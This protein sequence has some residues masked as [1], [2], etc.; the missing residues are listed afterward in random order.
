MRNGRLCDLP[1]FV[2]LL[3]TLFVS[4]C[5]STWRVQS[6]SKPDPRPQRRKSE[7]AA[8]NSE[9]AGR[10]SEIAGLRSQISNLKSATTKAHE[11]RAASGRNST[12]PAVGRIDLND[13]PTW[14]DTVAARPSPARVSANTSGH[15][16]LP[17]A[18][19]VRP[20][21]HHSVIRLDGWQQPDHI[22]QVNG[23]QLVQGQAIEVQ[24]PATALRPPG[25]RP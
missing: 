20:H 5:A 1:L 2:W 10:N 15:R 19:S 12:G 14:D 8:L 18:V 7:I 16:R 24:G 17:Q 23:N 6:V 4:G 9:I 13:E 25:R 3:T 11:T 22:Q 21:P